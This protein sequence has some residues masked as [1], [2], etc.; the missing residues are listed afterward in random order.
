[1][2]ITAGKYVLGPGHGRLVVLTQRTGAAAKAGHNLTMYVT[3]WEASVVVGETAADTAVDLNVDGGSLRVH[4]GKGGMQALGEDDK[5]DIEKTIDDEVLKR[6]NIT[7]HSTRTEP[8]RDGGGVSVAGDLTLNHQTHPISFDVIMSDTGHVTA[9]AE[10]KQTDFGMKPYSTL[11][12]AL[13]VVDEVTIQIDA[14]M[15]FS[16]AGQPAP[17]S[18]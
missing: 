18:L 12:G 1:V 16:P 11:F 6:E 7:F 8:L 5:A 10:I 14:T 3:A 2:P 4:E 13:K 17:Q 9:S 15:P